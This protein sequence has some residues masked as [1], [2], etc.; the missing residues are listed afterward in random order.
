M[1][2]LPFHDS[3]ARR[4]RICH[5]QLLPLLSGAQRA[6]LEIFNEIDR[7]RCELH[8]ACQGPGPLTDELERLKIRWHALPRLVRPIRPHH[9][10]QAYRA[11]HELF[12]TFRFDVVHTH[13]SKPGVLGRLAARRAGV[14]VVVHHT[15]GFAFHDFSPWL[16]RWIYSRAERWAGRYCDRVVFVN[17]E[18]RELSI[19]Q[20][21]LPA[22]KCLTVY[23]GVDLARITPAGRQAARQAGRERWQL[24]DDEVVI[25]FAGRLE[26]QKNP[27][28]LADIAAAL[29]RHGSA[30]PWR[31]VIAGDGPLAGELRWRLEAARLTDRVLLVGWQNDPRAA[32]A[33][34]D[35]ALLPSLF[36][37]L[38]LALI[39][40]QAA[41]L[42]IVA[43]NVKGN[44]EVVRDGTGFLCPP[45][46]PAAYACSLAQLINDP[47]LRAQFGEAA[48][49][50]SEAAFDAQRN[51]RRI[52]DL[53]D[54]LLGY[55]SAPLAERQAA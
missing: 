11:L 34:A 28:A 8:V 16:K 33:V 43:S 48:R 1:S 44:R 29:R 2:H 32:L 12:R 10:W 7:S 50:H 39:E 49:R 20:G 45:T 41:G 36:E 4:I 15:H 5:V 53:Y 22:E 38:S 24:S 19:R 37:G 26:S 6:M 54:E 23:N 14:P 47:A 13:S 9:D 46:E 30:S 31:L 51:H 3:R 35:V 40:A 27:L 25:V 52:A 55:R 18:E 21:W 42:P 17:R